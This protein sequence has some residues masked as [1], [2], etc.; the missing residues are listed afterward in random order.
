MALVSFIRDNDWWRGESFPIRTHTC[1]HTHQ[2][3]PFPHGI[4]YDVLIR[5]G[6]CMR[7][8]NR[9]RP[10]FAKREGREEDKGRERERGRNVEMRQQLPA[11]VIRI[12]LVKNSGLHSIWYVCRGFLATLGF[13]CSCNNGR[14]LVLNLPISF[15]PKHLVGDIARMASDRVRVTGLDPNLTHLTTQT[16]ASQSRK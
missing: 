5:H 12:G 16:V 3:V 11:V 9:Q 8:C 10:Q 1:T 14:I 7:A 6:C 4:I 15:T 13:R 2:S